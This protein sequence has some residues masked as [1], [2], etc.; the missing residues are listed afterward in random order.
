MKFSR[1]FA[2]LFPRQPFR[3]RPVFQF[4][5]Q[6]EVLEDRTAPTVTGVSLGNPGLIPATGSGDSYI[7]QVVGSETSANGQYAVY[8]SFSSNLVA[9]QTDAVNTLDV[10][11]YSLATGTNTLVS[12]L[13]NSPTTSADGGTSLVGGLPMPTISADGRYV[14]YE[15][16]QTD[17]VPGQ[18][19][20]AGQSNPIHVFLYD[21]V[22]NTSTLVDHNASSLVTT[23]NQG[24]GQAI[25]SADGNSIV[26]TSEASDLVANEVD[27]TSF[28]DNVYVYDRISGTNTLVS[29]A[30]GTPATTANGG[31]NDA[32]GMAISANGQFIA[33]TSKASNLVSGQIDN[34]TSFDLFLYNRQANTSTVVSHAYNNALQAVEGNATGPTMSADGRFV[35]YCCNGGSSLV[36]SQTGTLNGAIWLYDALAG[37]NV[38]VSHS[39]N[40]VTDTGNNGFG[41]RMNAEISADGNYV[42]YT[43]QS[44]LIVAGMSGDGSGTEVTNL[45]LYSRATGANVLVDHTPGTT[46]VV[47]NHDL[48]GVVP[49]PAISQ[50]GRYVAFLSAATNLLSGVATPICHV[51]LYDATTGLLTLVDR[52][53][54][55]AGSAGD[56]A[57]S[58][59]AISADGSTVAY[60]SA[61]DDLVSGLLDNN[62]IGDVFLY[63][64]AAQSS[65]VASRRAADVPEL[66]GN[67]PST[68]EQSGNRV[69]GSTISDDG[70]FV[71]FTSGASNLVPG[72][73][74][75]LLNIANDTNVYLFDRVTGTTTLVSLSGGFAVRHRELCFRRSNYQR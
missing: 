23:G 44:T 67:A 66:T 68:E 53:A 61:A 31:T 29:H 42:A 70:R 27:T 32:P 28:A 9:G 41:I 63:N 26:Y 2:K 54:V 51:Y 18:V 25:I 69:L 52:S 57:A 10:F 75:S 58:L 55:T 46:S 14:A 64:V 48:V 4:R 56:L 43:S 73:V 35:A 40:S 3:P 71:V 8:L 20:A 34:G 17:L 13:A 1:W 39:Y 62:R 47:G 16:T 38:L 50:D 59:V 30:V 11:L 15:T 72:E 22:T 74:D 12:H 60:V 7:G 19:E 65:N 24:V 6:V 49:V 45:F 36:A 33:F 5:P 37:T 21:R